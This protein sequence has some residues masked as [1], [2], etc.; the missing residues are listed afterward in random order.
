MP[1]FENVDAVRGAPVISAQAKRS[2]GRRDALCWDDI[3]WI[4]ERWQGKLV[5]KGVL[6]ADDATHAARICVNGVIVSSHGGRQL[7]GAMPA[8]AAL[9]DVRAASGAMTVTMDSGV[10]RGTDVLKAIALGATGV[11]VGRP[12]LYAA[13]IGGRAG[14]E[15][16]I[17]LMSLEIDRN[18][19]LPGCTNLAELGPSRLVPAYRPMADARHHGRGSKPAVTGSL[20]RQPGRARARISS[21][22]GRRI[23]ALRP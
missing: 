15:H 23:I 19:A 5:L 11:F 6:A 22:P 12:F 7:D 2:F 1:H 17:S 3:G 14:V 10:R 4:R 9:P 21:C 18:M 13:A 20:R 8:L 16:A